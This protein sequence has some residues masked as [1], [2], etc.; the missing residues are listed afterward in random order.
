MSLRES[1]R[2]RR[3]S[4]SDCGQHYSLCISDIPAF[5]DIE[6]DR[7]WKNRLNPFIQLPHKCMC[8]GERLVDISRELGFDA[9]SRAAFDSAIDDIRTIELEDRTVN[10]LIVE[11]WK[12]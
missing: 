10:A 2:C 4:G 8:D 12:T 3:F 5:S 7:K 6:S 1:Y 11:G 9:S